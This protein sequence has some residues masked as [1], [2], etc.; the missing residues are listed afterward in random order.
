MTKRTYQVSVT[1]SPELL[2]AIDREAFEGDETRASCIRR[3]LTDELRHVGRMS[4][5]A[6]PTTQLGQ[7]NPRYRTEAHP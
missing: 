1:L 3:I 2:A 4:L 6:P 7:N 5:K